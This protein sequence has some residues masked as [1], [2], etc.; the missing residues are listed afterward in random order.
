MSAI[1][2]HYLPQTGAYKVE[3]KSKSFVEQHDTARL[4]ISVGY[5][6]HEGEK[7][8]AT[9]EWLA[10]RFENVILIVSD[11]LQRHNTQ[12]WNASLSKE[13]AEIK[14]REIG[15]NWLKE[16]AGAISL[17]PSKIIIRHDRWLSHSL[18]PVYLKRIRAE[19]QNSKEFMDL[20]NEMTK[21]IWSRI[22]KNDAIQDHDYFRFFRHSTDFILEELAVK[23]ITLSQCSAA[24]MYPGKWLEEFYQ[25]MA[26]TP[27]LEMA[28]CF[29][30][31]SW[32]RFDHRRNK[33]NQADK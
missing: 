21:S 32:M 17:L 25:H 27:H 7:F 3:L 1:K 19:Y 4:H 31:S 23:A 24:D 28:H 6:N 10:Q 30:G 18:Y 15:D 20:C 29:S 33:I 22:S 12:F 11:T 13:E 16:N 2:K 26:N 9:C 8:Y 5:P 14:S